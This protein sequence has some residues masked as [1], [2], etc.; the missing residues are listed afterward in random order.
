MADYYDHQEPEPRHVEE[1]RT[2]IEHQCFEC[3]REGT[4]GCGCCGARLCYMHQET[5]AGFCSNFGTYEIDG[6]EKK[7]CKHGDDFYEF[8]NSLEKNGEEASE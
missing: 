1:E 3:S 7:G 5:Q 6:E 4:I 8:E 2:P